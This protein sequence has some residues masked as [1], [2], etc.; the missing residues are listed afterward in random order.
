ML[1]AQ[2]PQLTMAVCHTE[3][4]YAIKKTIFE[5][6]KLYWK[7]ALKDVTV[8]QMLTY[9]EQYQKVLEQRLE[10]K[11]VSDYKFNLGEKFEDRN[12]RITYNT[13]LKQED[14]RLLESYLLDE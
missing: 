7:D 14:P 5:K 8:N 13:F 6:A 10:E 2:T 12:C 11:L 1:S 4:S 3:A 9:A